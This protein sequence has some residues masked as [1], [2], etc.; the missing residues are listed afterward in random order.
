MIYDALIAPFTEFEFMRRALA[1]V[2][3]L[4]LGGAPIGVFLMLRRMSLMGDALSHAILP[5]AAIGYLLAGLSLFA[6][7]LGGFAAGLAVALLAGLVARSTSLKEDASL[8]AF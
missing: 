5:G 3:A 2:I 6:M 8:A 4:A 1:A 7:S